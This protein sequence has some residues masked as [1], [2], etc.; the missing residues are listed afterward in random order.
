MTIS[1]S[2]LVSTWSRGPVA[3][4]SWSAAPLSVSLSR[5]L[6][7]SHSHSSLSSWPSSAWILPETSGCVLPHVHN[8]T[9]ASTIPKT[10]R[11]FH[12]G[13]TIEEDATR[14]WLEP[15][16]GCSFQIGCGFSL[17]HRPHDSLLLS[18]YRASFTADCS[19]VFTHIVFLVSEALFLIAVIK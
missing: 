6:F 15:R 4:F 18:S 13:D 2:H 8:K 1:L 14:T 7:L 3:C 11:P 10:S 17:S 9:F 19:S 5:L 12:S 16:S